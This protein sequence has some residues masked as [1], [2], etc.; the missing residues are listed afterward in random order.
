[1]SYGMTMYN[2]LSQGL[3]GMQHA[4]L[5]QGI[6]LRFHDMATSVV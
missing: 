5:V 1:V 2:S 3:L 4:N 6:L